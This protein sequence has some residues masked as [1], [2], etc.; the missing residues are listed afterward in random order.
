MDDTQ[1]LKRK[2]PESFSWQDKA[3]LKIEKW[4]NENSLEKEA[5][6]GF[7]AVNMAST[8]KG[9]TFGNA[10]IMRALSK[11]SISGYEMRYILALGLR[12]LTLQT[13]EEYRDK[14]KASKEDLA[15]LIGSQTILDLNK[16]DIS[17]SDEEVRGSESEEQL[18][19]VEHDCDFHVDT[20]KQFK[21]LE[22]VLKKEKD[23]DLLCAPLLVCTIDHL[24]GATETI[25]GGRYILPSLRLMSSDLVIDEID[26]FG[27][28]DLKAIG[29][30]I[31]LS[32]M[33][34]RKV[35]I[36]SATIPPDMAKG[37]F[38]TY[39]EGW[40]LFAKSRGVSPELGCAWI[41]EFKTKVD[42]IIKTQDFFED[43]D[44][45]VNE[46][47]K[48]L[49]SQRAKRKAEIVHLDVKTEEDAAEEDY[50]ESVKKMAIQM[51]ERHFEVDEASGKKVSFGVVRVANIR[52][53]VK[54]TEY[55]LGCYWPTGLAIKTMAYHS[56][57]ILLMRN[58]QEKHLD[59][60]LNRKKEAAFQNQVIREHL[61][62]LK[63][64]NIFYV[65]VATP[66]EEIGRDHDFDWAIIE[67]SSARSIIQLSGRVLRH[68]Q[69]IPSK[70]NVAIMQYNLKGHKKKKNPV[71]CRPGYESKDNPLASVDVEKVLDVNLLKNSIDAV[72]R[73][74]R[75]GKNF[76][77]KG[78]LVD[79]EHDVIQR[80]LNN[81]D[82]KGVG[83]LE[84][85]VSEDWWLTGLSGNFYR[86]RNDV[87]REGQ[88]LP[89]P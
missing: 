31:H 44:K 2:S 88:H 7:F 36:S 49:K 46:R 87:A 27:I 83:N 53:C 51:H 10:K 65:L 45:F 9:K 78:N 68:R 43:H 13:G 3:V 72:P 77:P 42:K 62:G 28:E 61:D 66:V 89:V 59:D 57:Q 1:E 84:G 6:F 47:T 48:N 29:K 4:R 73:I 26:D 33:L 60:V 22:T 55:F 20:W 70:P 63:E 74:K 37:F 71:F 79:L 80:A 12:T 39:Q 64:E 23:R 15:V 58:E 50:F 86:F 76:D 5:R 41:D 85:W 75:N 11:M 19:E 14:M 67:P 54:L 34:G 8:G 52:T 40:K 16:K 81:S 18:L 69:K 21:F 82:A 24:M 38:R 56:R 25:R 32:G 35:M 17:I 30:L